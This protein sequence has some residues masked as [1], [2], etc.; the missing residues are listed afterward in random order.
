MSNLN[1]RSNQ[2]QII[3]PT[4]INLI[5]PE[6]FRDA[7]SLDTTTTA[8]VCVNDAYGRSISGHTGAGIFGS[9][10]MAPASCDLPYQSKVKAMV[11]KIPGFLFSSYR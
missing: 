2:Q 8:R 10:L 9:L 7:L 6:G 4:V 5:L 1:K 3:A 11:T